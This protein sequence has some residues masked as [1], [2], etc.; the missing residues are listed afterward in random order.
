[1]VV[2]VDLV[3]PV[4]AAAEDREFLGWVICPVGLRAVAAGEA[5]VNGY[6]RLQYGRYTL[7]NSV[8]YNKDSD[9]V[10]PTVTVC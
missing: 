3:D 9:T 10:Y 8:K 7:M 2:V 6:K 4:V 5:A 1:M